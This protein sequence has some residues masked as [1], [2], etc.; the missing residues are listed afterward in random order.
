MTISGGE[1]LMH[2]DFLIELLD[3]LGEMNIH[4]AVDT[5]GHVP[6][7]VLMEVARR[8]DLF[9]YDLKMMDSEKHKAYTGVD[10]QLILNN[11]QLLATSGAEINIRIPLIGGVNTDPD[12]IE[13]SAAFIA[14]LAGKKKRVNLLPY[15]NIACKKYEKLGLEYDGSDF[16]E[17]SAQKLR[18][19]V[20]IFAKYD[21]DAIAGG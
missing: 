9:L 14:S 16:E 11:L 19:I 7:S 10:N 21:I 8:T 15:H 20:E 12:N 17:P 4:R 3:K 18:E 1:P 13:Q 6:A 5:C 2:A